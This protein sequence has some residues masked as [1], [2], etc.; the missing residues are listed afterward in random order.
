MDSEI[1]MPYFFFK[2]AWKRLMWAIKCMEEIDVG[3]KGSQR[4]LKNYYYHDRTCNC[5]TSIGACSG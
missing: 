1:M 4:A 3:Y 2:S 5:R